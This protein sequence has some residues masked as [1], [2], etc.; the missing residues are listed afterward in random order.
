MIPDH[1]SVGKVISKVGPCA[2][3]VETKFGSLR[4]NRC[5]LIALRNESA[6][7]DEDIYICQVAVIQLQTVTPQPTRKW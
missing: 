3:L 1:N 6:K 5:H 4:R 7:V 2:S